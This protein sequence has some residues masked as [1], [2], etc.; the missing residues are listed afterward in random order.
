MT[1]TANHSRVQLLGYF[2]WGNFGDDLFRE[3]CQDRAS[4]L[5]PDSQV[6]VFEE[7]TSNFS[8]RSVISRA[9]RF[10]T[11]AQGA[12]WSNTFAYCGG[13]VFSEIA[14]ISALRTRLFRSHRF[15]ALG[16]SVGPFVHNNDLRAVVQVL[17]R[18]DRVIVRDQESCDR[19]SG[20]CELGGDLA[21]LSR[22]FSPAQLSADPP[23]GEGITICPSSAADTTG[24]QLT[25]AIGS[26]LGSTDAI[27]TVLALNSHPQLGDR[28]VAET[29]AAGLRDHGRD[30]RVLNYG[31]IGIGGVID[32]LRSSKLVWS[33]RLHGAIASYLSGVPTAIVD[34]HEKCGAFA[35]DIGLDHRFLVRGFEELAPTLTAIDADE[36]AVSAA[37]TR[38][39]VDYQQRAARVYSHTG[40]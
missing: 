35:R 2:G 29:I 13:S 15:E 18:F 12:L 28:R 38:S 8:P 33:Q 34:H 17:R 22:R 1:R 27:I 4:S 21:A 24:P 19:L 16:V 5:W 20:E 23:P 3:T 26:A 40:D 7:H 6:R 11:A 39:A 9:R 36:F 32:V 31:S 14:G 25:E 30:V 37:W 10:G